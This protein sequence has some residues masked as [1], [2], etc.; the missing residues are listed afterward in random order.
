[1]QNQISYFLHLEQHWQEI[2]KSWAW[3][4]NRYGRGQE[5]AHAYK[6]F[7]KMQLGI[8]KSEKNTLSTWK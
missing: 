1:M 6:N 8:D 7:F 4:G 3:S 5:R 2:K